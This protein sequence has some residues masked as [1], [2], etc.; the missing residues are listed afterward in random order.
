VDLKKVDLLLLNKLYVIY[1]DVV[2]DISDVWK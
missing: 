2:S 1:S